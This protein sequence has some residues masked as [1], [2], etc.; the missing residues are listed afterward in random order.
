MN[1]VV[2]GTQ[3]FGDLLNGWLSIAKSF[4]LGR[5][6]LV[7][8][9]AHMVVPFLHWADLIA[10]RDVDLGTRVERFDIEDVAS[11]VQFKTDLRGKWN[12]VQF[13][14][15]IEKPEEVGD[16]DIVGLVDSKHRDVRVVKA[17]DY[18]SQPLDVVQWLGYH[19]RELS[20]SCFG[21]EG[22]HEN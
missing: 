10:L 21:G 6:P 11:F 5:C 13:E 16:L 14:G 3:I 17:L 4:Y 15:G 20:F 2:S 7:E 8:E 12:L 22:A 9:A 19:L 18:I 1:R